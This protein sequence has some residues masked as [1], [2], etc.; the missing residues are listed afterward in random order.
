MGYTFEQWRERYS[1]RSDISSYL[2]H[3]TRPIFNKEGET[4][5]T[6]IDVLNEILTSKKLIGSTTQKG[7]IVGKNKAVCF[8]DMPLQSVC[9]NVLFEELRTEDKKKRRYV[10]IGI[11]FPK[12][13][14][15]QKG[16]RPVM[17]EK[18]K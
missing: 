9:Q 5:K 15:Y 7:Y 8:Q 3:L 4:I 10:P 13:Y 6:S 18:K 14:V 2:V 12:T 17:Y 16:G 1:Q 11:A